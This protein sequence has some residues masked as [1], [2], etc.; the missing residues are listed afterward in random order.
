MAP[1]P[2][3]IS[4][5]VTPRKDWLYCT[6]VHEVGLFW[7]YTE[8]GDTMSI[9]PSPSISLTSRLFSPNP[10]PTTCMVHVSVIG[11]PPCPR[12]FSNHTTSGSPLKVGSKL[13]M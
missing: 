3:P 2:E 13:Q 10:G 4:S 9:L 8:D 6:W 11:F 1:F 7:K 5:R 12:G